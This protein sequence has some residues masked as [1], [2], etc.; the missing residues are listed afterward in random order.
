M[1]T[2][3]LLLFVTAASAVIVVP[4]PTTL[5]AVSNGSVGGMRLALFGIAG[6]ILSDV[7]LIAAV[8]A[9]FGALLATSPAA[10]GALKIVGALY[11]AW[12]ALQFWRGPPPTTSAAALGASPAAAFG[13]SLM[14]ALTNPKGWL[15]FVAFL[16]PFVDVRQALL[17]QY[18]VLGSIF[19]AIDI[20][21]MSL[22]AL[23][24]VLTSRWSARGQHLLQRGAALVLAA[25]AVGLV[26]YSTAT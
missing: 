10:V 15:F 1:N 9:G 17:P 20:A 5:L 25:L 19:C 24:G 26:F 7:L 22:Y 16:L 23:A 18:L 8:G 2:T 12:L 6:A 11:L 4:G 3:T 21:V 14:V 13:R